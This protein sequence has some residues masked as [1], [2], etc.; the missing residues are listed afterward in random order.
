LPSRSPLYPPIQEIQKA[1]ER[2]CSLTRQLLAFSRK[3]AIE[4]RPTSVNSVVNDAERMLQRLIGEDIELVTSLDPLLG[5]VM[6]DPGQIHQVIMNLVVN[7]RDAMADGGKLEIT[8]ANI[9]LD[10]TAAGS[11]IDAV[12]GRHV[13][14][15]VTDTGTGMTEETMQSIFDPFFTT[16]EQGKGTGLGLTTAYGIVRQ[17]GGWIEVSSK[18]GE[19]TTF[20][21]YLPRIDGTP[22]S[23]PVD[24]PCDQTRGGNETILVVEDQEEV[25]RLTR[26]VLESYGYTVVEAGNATEA[27]QAVTGRCSEIHLLLTDVIL[28]G[29][30]GKAL[31]EE[32]LALCPNLKVI[33]TSGYPVDVVSNRG[34]LERDAAYLAKPFTPDALAAKV[35]EV[36]T[37]SRPSGRGA[38]DRRR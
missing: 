7:A 37:E 33:F 28:P 35:R 27:L 30:D 5:L 3:Q 32:L 36:L 23:D 2:A 17:A 15:T 11:H 6:A 14:L 38:A 18:L 4:P 31:S 20:R 16:K 24:P 13:V 19:G 29:M 34:I 1:G 26:I 12:F 10:E 9:D 25:R 8:T 22:A 21:I